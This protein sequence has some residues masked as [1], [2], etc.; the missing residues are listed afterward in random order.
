MKANHQWEADGFEIVIDGNVFF[1]NANFDWE[2]DAID[3]VFDPRRGYAGQGRDTLAE[4]AFAVSEIEIF[5]ESDESPV[6]LSYVKQI[7]ETVLTMFRESDA[8]VRNIR[9]GAWM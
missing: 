1:V 3:Y 6:S 9:P 2:R 8:G 5:G 7:R 4:V